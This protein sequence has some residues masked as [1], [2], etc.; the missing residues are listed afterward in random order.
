MNMLCIKKDC[1][2]RGISCAKCMVKYHNR[3]HNLEK[4]IVCVEEAIEH[5]QS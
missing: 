4:D 1:K 2:Y 5:L 3:D